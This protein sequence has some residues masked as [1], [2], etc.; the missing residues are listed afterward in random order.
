VLGYGSA[1]PSSVA[2]IRVDPLGGEQQRPRKAADDGAN[3]KFFT[4]VDRASVRE[5]DRGT[6]QQAK[7]RC[8]RGEPDGLDPSSRGSQPRSGS[9]IEPA[10]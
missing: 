10:D 7:Y 9:D 3:D 1:K 6:G 2:L 4:H 5:V 8:E